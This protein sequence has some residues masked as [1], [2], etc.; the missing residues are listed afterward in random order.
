MVMTGGQRWK[1]RT[2]KSWTGYVL[3]K[4][5]DPTFNS[6]RVVYRP[7]ELL[8]LLKKFDRDK[9]YGRAILV[10]ES[11]ELVDNT[12]WQKA[13][14]KAIALAIATGG[15]RRVFI[16]WVTPTFDWIAKRIRR[17]I[18][19]WGSTELSM[20]EGQNY[21]KCKL[22]YYEIGT[23]EEGDKIFK[24]TPKYYDNLQHRV[25]YCNSYDV[26][27]FAKLYPDDKEE[28][29]RKS[30]AYKEELN[31][32]ITETIRI[33]EEDVFKTKKTSIRDLNL[34]MDQALQFDNIKSKL[35]KKGKVSSVDVKF[36][37][38]QNGKVM[39]ANVCGMIAKGLSE[40]EFGNGNRTD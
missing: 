29:E 38:M 28:Y 26:S 33:S 5:I 15:Y 17:L 14:N 8:N 4:Q 30:V 39:P 16:V 13:M 25:V 27:S 37:Y 7:S 3:C 11:E 36:A 21:V 22:H 10:D 34:L 24:H 1:V 19:A 18:N 31:A 12:E 23:D 9:E 2:G 20:S 40:G 35:S 6:S 32:T